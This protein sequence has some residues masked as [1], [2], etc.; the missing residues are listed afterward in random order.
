VTYYR[1]SG[2]PVTRDFWREPYV[3]GG[4]GRLW[5]RR[6]PWF[7]TI[8]T[9][10]VYQSWYPRDSWIPRYT[11]YDQ[12]LN[13]D[14]YLDILPP[15]AFQMNDINWMRLP[16]LPTF[17]EAQI[18]INRLRNPNQR[19]NPEQQQYAESTIRRIDSVLNR[20][21]NM[22][23]AEISMGY[24]IVPDLDRAVFDWVKVVQ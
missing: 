17:S 20:L 7:A 12:Y 6:Y 16:I 13:Q 18:D 15:E 3:R 22:Y 9:P 5:A 14:D 10:R 21:R 2:Y 24:Q 11:I 1:E 23:K 8:F 4:Y 19:L